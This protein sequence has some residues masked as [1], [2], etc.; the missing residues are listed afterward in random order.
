MSDTETDYVRTEY[1]ETEYDG[2]DDEPNDD[3]ETATEHEEEGGT[4]AKKETR[5]SKGPTISATEIADAKE[6][7]MPVETEARPSQALGSGMHTILAT[8]V[9]NKEVG[10]SSAPAATMH[11]TL[12]T[13][14]LKIL[15]V[16]WAELKQ[17]QGNERKKCWKVIAQEVRAR[18]EHQHM[19]MPEWKQRLKTCLSWMHSQ[20]KG[21]QR[22]QMQLSQKWTARSVI[23][24]TWKD[25]L[26]RLI[27]EMHGVP[28]GSAEMFKHY[29]PMLSQVIGSMTKEEMS[30][31]QATADEWNRQGTPPEAQARQDFLLR[32]RVQK[33]MKTFTKE[34]WKKGGIQMVILSGFKDKKGEI[35]SQVYDFNP[36]MADG[37][38]FNSVE[39]AQGAF[40]QFLLDCFDPPKEATGE[41]EKAEGQSGERSAA[42][43]GK[44]K[45]SQN[46]SR[47]DAVRMVT[48]A[49]GTIW[50]P[51]LNGLKRLQM[52]D[53]VRSF[54]TAHYRRVCCNPKASA[55]FKSLGRYQSDL[56]SKSHLPKEF[57]FGG[58]LAI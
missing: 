5:P 44:R 9:P 29:Q 17:A 24:E 47:E 36:D 10:P 43:K 54:L 52:Q 46:E 13:D 12:P 34:M 18:P 37:L 1:Q 22:G 31:A 48:K 26:K 42:P 19:A 57:T 58:T 20:G 55:P 33:A 7:D 4:P 56:V 50:I 3:L 53:M 15:Q 2:S 51:E 45:K 27:E 35:F 30:R 16:R 21:K 25:D 8:D 39:E 49:D 38:T 28:P 41:A 32:I 11:P 23:R 6:G 14:V 40:D